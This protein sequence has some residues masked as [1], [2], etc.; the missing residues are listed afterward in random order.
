MPSLTYGAA[1]ADLAE[2]VGLELQE[3]RE[4]EGVVGAGEVDL[5]GPDA[6]VRPEDVLGVA[7]GDLGGR[8]DLEVHVGAR[9]ADPA[10]DRADQDRAAGAGRA[11]ARRW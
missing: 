3:R 7:P 6:G 11:R 8:P 9:L 4:G 1:F 5:L 10:G 2:A